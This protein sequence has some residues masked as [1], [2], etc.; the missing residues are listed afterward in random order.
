[1]NAKPNMRGRRQDRKGQSKRGDRFLKLNHYMLESVA[2]RSLKTRS[3]ALYVL[4]AQRYNGSNNGDIFLSIRDS[5]HELHIAK[6]TATKSFRELEEKGFI[7]AKQKGSFH[8][9]RRHATT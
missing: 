4:L 7:R 5:T 6:D 2:W 3:R 1:M 9:K 8:W